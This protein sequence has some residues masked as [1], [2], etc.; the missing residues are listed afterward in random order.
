MK[1]MFKFAVILGA[2]LL[3]TLALADAGHDHGGSRA[4]G[5]P[6]DPK[7][8]N[9]TIEIVMKETDDGKMI[10]EPN[11]VS[12]SKGEQ[13]RFVLKNEGQLDHEFMLATRAE[14][15]K[16]AIAMQKAPDMEHDDPNGRRIAPGKTDEIIWKFSKSGEF[17]FACLIPGHRESG[18][19]GSV[20]VK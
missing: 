13:I 15:D 17:N 11:S 14:N 2:A 1:Q 5:E 18:M 16:H 4:Y 6:G 10:F 20:A 7:K 9:R 3:P 8:P 19:D 12:A